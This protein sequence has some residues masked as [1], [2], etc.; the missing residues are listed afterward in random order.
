MLWDKKVRPASPE[1]QAVRLRIPV[2]A[3]SPSPSATPKLEVP[4]PDSAAP[5]I[6]SSLPAS[7]SHSTVL[8]GTLVLKGELSGKE[9][10]LIEGQ[11]DGSVDVPDHTLTVGAQGHVKA[12]IRARQVIVH[13]SVEGKVTAKDKVDLRKTGNVIGDLV[14][15][16]VSIEDGAYFKGSIEIV[17][18]G[19]AERPR[20]SV[21]AKTAV[22]SVA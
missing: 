11:F 16:S 10:L 13:G 2:P 18:E 3:P 1:P 12:D 19:A 15:A 9:D 8:G 14:S 21:A 20:P 17:R 5:R 6:S 4:M 7:S 22:S